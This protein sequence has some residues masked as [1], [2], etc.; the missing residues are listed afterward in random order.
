LV[1]CWQYNMKAMMFW[2][3]YAIFYWLAIFRLIFF[4]IVDLVYQLCE[5]WFTCRCCCNNL[6]LW[7]VW[8]CDHNQSRCYMIKTSEARQTCIL[9]FC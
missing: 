8:M 3:M 7:P 9:L 5:I 6:Q 2:A 1:V 4:S